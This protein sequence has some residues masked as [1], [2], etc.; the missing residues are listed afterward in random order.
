MVVLH[1]HDGSF[2]RVFSSL[3][4]PSPPSDSSPPST[5]LSVPTSQV[6]R[7]SSPSAPAPSS[8]TSIEA[9]FEPVRLAVDGQELY[10]A[11]TLA[12]RVLILN[13]DT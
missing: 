11:D 5:T 9:R 3:L 10:V 13:K 2:V 4:P 1:K 7:A 8:H 12:H 6:T